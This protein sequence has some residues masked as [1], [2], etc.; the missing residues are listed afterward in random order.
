MPDNSPRYVFKHEK[1]E[2]PLELLLD[3]IEEE[4][5]SISEVSLAKITD[6]YLSYVKTKSAIPP[7][8]LA[9]FLVVAAQ[10][11]L[12]KSRSLLPSLTLTEEE[13]ASIDELAARLAEYQK[14]RDY[15]KKLKSIETAHWRIFAREGYRGVT[16][17][18]YPPPS[19]Q[20]TVLARTFAAFLAALPKIE[21]LAEDSIKKIISLEEKIKHIQATLQHAVERAFSDVVK[22][23]KEKVEVIVSFLAI[24]ELARQKFVDLEQVK[25]FA[26]I[27][28]KRRVL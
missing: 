19:L 1:F 15:A 2:G 16:P 6:E 22:G 4:K 7:E 13:T 10:L 28:I 24:L 25:A 20:G 21:K 5:L 14:F 23:A 27:T 8:V 26:D 3:L 12:I 9:D 18:F 17:L 11:M